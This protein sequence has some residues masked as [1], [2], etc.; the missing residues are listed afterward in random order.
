M[1][2]ELPRNVPSAQQ[3]IKFFNSVYAKHDWES[4]AD[5]VGTYLIIIAC[6]SVVYNRKGPCT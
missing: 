6:Y 5:T 4:E 1:V 3:I 2:M